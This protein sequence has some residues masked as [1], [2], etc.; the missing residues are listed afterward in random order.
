VP[1][2]S[3]RRPAPGLSRW[4]E[5]F[6]PDNRSFLEIVNGAP[7]PAPSC[8]RHFGAS[9]RAFTSRLSWSATVCA[10]AA[11][12]ALSA[13]VYATMG[14]LDE[15][16]IAGFEREA[17]EPAAAAWSGMARIGTARIDRASEAKPSL[18]ASEPAATDRAARL[19]AALAPAD[20]R[21]P[22]PQ[23]ANPADMLRWDIVKGADG[24][25]SRLWGRIGANETEE[26]FRRLSADY[27][28]LV[29]ERDRLRE[30]IS[31]LEQTLFLSQAPQAPRQLARVPP[32]DS[33]GASSAKP[34]AAAIAFPSPAAAAQKNF[35]PP[36]SVPNY[37]S[38]ESGAILGSRSTR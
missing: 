22:D 12:V 23:G 13:A 27:A 17:A 37:F 33:F 11:I 21:L 16:P 4:E 8:R 31:E 14:F 10:G 25:V 7:A 30:R 36:S 29:E 24:R 5:R 18:P 19:I 35:T 32:D 34:G 2:I 20:P 1:L 38:D 15:K 6:L 26:Q 9:T 3:R 28:E